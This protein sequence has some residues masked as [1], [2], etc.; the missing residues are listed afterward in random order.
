MFRA[1]ILL[2]SVHVPY[3]VV[4][5]CKQKGS[6]HGV[7]ES[8]V[9]TDETVYPWEVRQFKSHAKLSVYKKKLELRQVRQA[10]AFMQVKQVPLHD[11]HILVVLSEK[12]RYWE[13]LP[14]WVTQILTSK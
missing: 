11:S 8:W 5:H 3:Y 6:A 7:Q 10:V 14:Q 13:E 12:R 2:Q 4:L 1:E 9:L